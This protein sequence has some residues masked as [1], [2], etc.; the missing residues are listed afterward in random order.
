MQLTGHPD[1]CHFN[2]WEIIL[3]AL[4]R[5]RFVKCIYSACFLYG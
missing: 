1:S 2:K 3:C 4:K 5:S